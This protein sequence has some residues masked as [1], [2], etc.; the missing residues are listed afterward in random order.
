MAVLVAVAL[1]LLIGGLLGLLGG[2]GAILT[3]PVLVYVVE[4]EPAAAVAM[5]LFFVGTTSL[6]GAGVQARA[7]RVRWKI[8]AIFGAA[9]MAGAFAGGRLAHLVP[10]TMLLVVFAAVMLVTALSMLEGRA[11][12]AT[13][14]RPLAV[15]QLLSLGA[16]VG[17]VS[18]FVGAGGGFLIVPAL[19]L[20]GGL[21]M[22]EAVGTSLFVIALQSFAGLAGHIGHVTVDW[23]LALL[24]TAAAV[25][26]MVAGSFSGAKL[27]ADALR[28]A[29]AWLVLAMG[30][31]VLG[32]Q[33]PLP[34][35]VFVG[36]AVLSAALVI[37][38]KTTRTPGRRH[39]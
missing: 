33:L 4:V 10:A 16:A 36:A 1:S 14:S 27:S 25:V 26:G 24:M 12:R 18:G 31:F 3:V 35:M 7:G 2:G 9:A 22:Q 5:S 8:G 13:G 20:V 29:F 15:V 38:R 11:E 17:V 32:K 34:W 39:A 28:R 21:A 23:R 19:T 6:V 37:T 30:L